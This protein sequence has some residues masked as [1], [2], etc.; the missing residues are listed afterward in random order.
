MDLEALV[1]CFV[2]VAVLLPLLELLTC[3]ISLCRTADCEESSSQSVVIHRPVS[4]AV[5]PAVLAPADVPPVVHMIRLPLPPSPSDDEDEEDEEEDDAWL[6]HSP[7]GRRVREV[8]PRK[9][10]LKRAF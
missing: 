4:A 5:V 2:S 6:L 7:N 10:H 3:S 1:A 8:R 9:R